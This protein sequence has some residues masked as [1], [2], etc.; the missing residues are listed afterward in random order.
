M[1]KQRASRTPLAMVLGLLALLVAPA[2]AQAHDTTAKA[3]CDLV[4]G[5][6]TVTLKVTFDGFHEAAQPTVRGKV[7]LSE[8]SGSEQ[9]WTD[10]APDL[11][12]N[13]HGDAMLTKTWTVSGG[14]TYTAKAYFW[15]YQGDEKIT[16]KHWKTVECPEPPAP[17]IHLDKTGVASAEAGETVTYE[18]AAKN[19]G[20][21]PLDDVTLTDDKC[22]ATLARAAGE[23]DTEFD[24]GDVWNYTC[25]AV[26]PAGVTS[27]KNVAQVCGTYNP[28]HDSGLEP[29]DVCDTDEHEFPVPPVEPPVEPPVSPPVSPPARE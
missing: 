23:T 13:D 26:V 25:T 10:N 17:A 14:G 12:W 3:R 1:H 21:V 18:F 2:A 7:W 5:Q 19:T 27:V 8:V 20:N 4:A 11:E 22:Q 29:K 15:W 9:S 16:R 6:P 28:P 24:P